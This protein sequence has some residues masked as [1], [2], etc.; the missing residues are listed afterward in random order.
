MML[1]GITAVVC[2]RLKTSLPFRWFWAGAG[3]WTVAVAI[4][5]AIAIR[6]N[7]FVFGFLERAFTSILGS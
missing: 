6:S 5:F 4:K 2:W 7:P 1:V 3:L